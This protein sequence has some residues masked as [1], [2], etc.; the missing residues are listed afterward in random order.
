MR[1]LLCRSRSG[2]PVPLLTITDF[3]VAPEEI[4]RR[5][6]VVLS[7]R[8]HPGESPASYMIDGVVDFL[9]SDEP[10]ARALRRIAVVKIVP[11][12]NPDGVAGGNHRCNLS[13]HDLNRRWNAPTEKLSPTIYHLKELLKTHVV[14]APELLAASTAAAVDENP[15]ACC[16]R[17]NQAVSVFCDFHA[18][19]GK[20]NIFIYGC[21]S[22]HGAERIFPFL[23]SKNAQTFSY[24][25][26]SFK[27]QKKKSNCG[28]VVAHKELGVVNSYTV[29]ALFSVDH[30]SFFLNQL[31]SP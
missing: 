27:V 10:E 11:M 25:D 24:S 17:H 19:S 16:V 8:V 18:H 1:T 29:R 5:K 15:G 9:C 7:G 30:F 4:A 2:N 31:V 6:Y 22:K 21:E 14:Q 12:L 23:L 13:G 20:K 26:C 3:S 28:R